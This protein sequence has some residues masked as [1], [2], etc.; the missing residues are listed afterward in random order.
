MA[1]KPA[2]NK[3]KSFCNHFVRKN[4]N[5]I[6][7][8]YILKILGNHWSSQRTPGVFPKTWLINT[9]LGD[10]FGSQGVHK[11]LVGKCFVN[12]FIFLMLALV[13]VHLFNLFVIN[14]KYQIIFLIYNLIKQQI[15][16][17][18]SQFD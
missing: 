9:G 4:T 6:S 2:V 18:Q 15:T 7:K 1:A 11:F 13:R 10:L 14:R 16:K 3:N 8:K 17:H 5:L 12:F